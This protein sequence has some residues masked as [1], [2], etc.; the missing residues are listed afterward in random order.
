MT[1]YQSGESRVH[2]LNPITKL[3][4]AIV[5]IIAAFAMNPVWFPA[6]LWVLL[7]L[8]AAA[9]GALAR[10]CSVTL[11][12]FAP[13]LLLIFLAQ[14]LFYPGEGPVLAEFGPLQVQQD[15]LLFATQTGLRLLVLVDA[16]LFLLLT[17]HPGTLMTAL[18]QRGLPPNISYVVSATL[19]IIPTFRDRAQLI[20]QAQ[21]ARG[22]ALDGGPVRRARTLLPLV[23]PLVLGAFTDVEERAIAMEARA[24]GAQTR[25]TNFEMVPDSTGQR[26]GRWV[27]WI[28]AAAAL[29]A[30]ALGVFS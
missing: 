15:G 8:A 24:F 29:A 30:N 10:F 22:L 19:Q 18:V 12:F 26:V 13:F 6:L 4:F 27:L 28:C 21:Q 17:T 11:K 14:G 23:G 20:R 25:R 3:V 1:F 2:R 7:V 16:F 5:V 9:A